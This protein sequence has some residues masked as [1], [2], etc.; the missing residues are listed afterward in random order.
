LIG[1]R[2]GARIDTPPGA[3]DEHR[4]FLNRYYG[5]SRLFYDATRKY[6]LFGRDDAL[7]GLVSDRS[8]RSLVEVGPGTGRNLARLHRARPDARLGGVEACDAMLAHAR[9]RCPWASLEHGFAED[10]CLRR[11]L[12]APP[13]RVLLSYC[14]SMVRDRAAAIANARRSLAD[15]GEVVAVDFGDFGG[16]PAPVARAFRAYLRA[17]RVE[18]LDGAVLAGARSIRYG[19]ARYYVIARFA[20]EPG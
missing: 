9:A 15:G 13:D 14:L 17:F 2:T 19:P 5:P 6:Y 11:V 18:P 16:L 10:A 20:R 12:D 1:A 3:R 4:A 8:W 7:R